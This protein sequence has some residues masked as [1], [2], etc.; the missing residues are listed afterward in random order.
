MVLAIASV[1]TSQKGWGE[2]YPFYHWKL[3]SQPL[4]TKKIHTEYRVY[5]RTDTDSVYK[6]QTLISTPTFNREEYTYTLDYL[7]ETSIKD[8]LNHTQAKSRL[9]TF[10]KHNHPKAKSFKII[11]ESFNPMQLLK[12]SSDYT[13]ATILILPDAR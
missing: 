1:G 3:F 8:S 11:S 10:L 12:D 7:I 13:S 9:L 4:G 6:R 5:L 2:I